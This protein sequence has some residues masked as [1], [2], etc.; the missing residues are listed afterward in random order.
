MSFECGLCIFAG[1]F[2]VLVFCTFLEIMQSGLEPFEEQLR[3]SLCILLKD[4]LQLI[5]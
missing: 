2:S 5:V 3:V 4:C 1:R